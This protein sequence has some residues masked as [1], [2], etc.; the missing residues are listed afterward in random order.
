MSGLARHWNVISTLSC[1]RGA[2]YRCGVQRIIAG[3]LRGRRLLDLPRELA[4][5]RPTGARARGAIFD[6]LQHEVVNANVLD[7]FAGT[8]ALGL[9]ALSRGAAA[10]SFVEQ[11]R[12]VHQFLE[13]QIA[14][15]RVEPR[16]D[17]SRS[18]ARAFL[19]RPAMCAYDL[20]FVDP[21]Y[22]A[23]ESCRDIA[24]LLLEFRWLAPSAIVR[25]RARHRQESGERRD[26]SRGV[27]RRRA[28]TLRTDRG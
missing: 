1:A 5:V 23:P 27:P 18:D 25:A 26:L 15:L 2:S 8:G 24:A 3:S 16:C 4:E 17:V 20:V 11:S 6:R 14:A 28:S 22:A 9:E 13:R 12:R 21:P 7:V 19:S 10:V